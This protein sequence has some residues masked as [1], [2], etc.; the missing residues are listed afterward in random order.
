MDKQG[1]LRAL[2]HQHTVLSNGIKNT[3]S[4]KGI[5]HDC[6]ILPDQL[7]EKGYNL[8]VDV[9]FSTEHNNVDGYDALVERKKSKE[10]YR[11]MTIVRSEEATSNT[12]SGAHFVGFGLAKKIDPGLSPE[13]ITD[14]IKSQGA[15][16]AAVHAYGVSNGSKDKAALCDMMEVFNANCVDRHSNSRQ[17]RFARERGMTM[18]AGSDSHVVDT[19]GLCTNLID[20][21]NNPDSI[22]SALKS[23][24][25]EIERVGYAS[26]L[27]MLEHA[28]YVFSMSRSGFLGWADREGKGL[29]KFL[30]KNALPNFTDNP[31]SSFYQRVAAFGLYVTTV[32]SEKANV[33]G[34]DFDR[35]LVSRDAKYIAQNLLPEMALEALS[36]VVGRSR[37]QRKL[38]RANQALMK[39]L[40]GDKKILYDQRAL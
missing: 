25:I 9:I 3:L 5:R 19:I 15:V 12:E 13:E 2:M 14:E 10:K 37:Y 34:K 1:R 39:D 33:E 22:V 23:G 16:S 24:K 29:Y 36:R 17:L 11:N 31:Y 21:D 32:L 35:L 20:S 30:I 8:G 38:A 40:F 18:F 6:K 7:L 26:H 28:Q 4:K 27:D